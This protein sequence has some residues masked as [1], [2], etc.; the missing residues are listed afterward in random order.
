LFEYLLLDP[1]AK[2][3]QIVQRGIKN[4]RRHDPLLLTFCAYGT[5]SGVSFIQKCFERH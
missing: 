5:F 4:F 3:I 1:S 2:G